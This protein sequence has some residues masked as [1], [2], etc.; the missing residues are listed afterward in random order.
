MNE[1]DWTGRK[2]ECDQVVYNGR[3]LG[4]GECNRQQDCSDL[5]ATND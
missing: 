2:S 1:Y 5:S 4:P 3:D